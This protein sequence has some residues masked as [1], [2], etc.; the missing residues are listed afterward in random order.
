MK[1]TLTLIALVLLC[2]I[3]RSERILPRVIEA[4]TRCGFVFVMGILC[5]YTAVGTDDADLYFLTVPL[6]VAATAA[7]FFLTHKA[8]PTT[9]AKKFHRKPER[10]SW[11]PTH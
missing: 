10:R 6:T 5:T 3:P 9:T 8:A 11:R 7:L 2:G 1:L 4:M